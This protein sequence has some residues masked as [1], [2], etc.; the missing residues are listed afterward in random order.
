MFTRIL[1]GCLPPLGR[2]SLSSGAELVTVTGGSGYLGLELVA[3]LLDRNYRVTATVRSVADESK[4]QPLQSLDSAAERLTILEADLLHPGSFDPCVVGAR[5]LFHTASPFRLSGVE[6]P[7]T[8]LIQPAVQGTENVM[9]AA[10]AAGVTRVVLTSS[11]AAIM[12]RPTDKDGP[13]DENDWNYSSTLGGDGLDWYRLSKKLA[14]ERAWEIAKDTGLEL[15]VICP[16]VIIGPPRTPRTDSESLQ[17]MDSVISGREP[18]RG[19]TPM[20]DVRDC[21]AAHI[22]AAEVPEANGHRFLTTTERSI[23]PPEMVHAVKRVLPDLPVVDVGQASPVESRRRIFASK[24]IR[25]LGM[26]FRSIEES[27][28]DMALKMMSLRT[29]RARHGAR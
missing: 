18:T 9:L 28:S 12:G 6:D 3:Q 23:E 14:E 20:V 27:L 15:A 29:E 2:R 4:V 5:T 17:L 16:S 13:F 1:R 25:I 10:A 26:E 7:E 22:A 24:T 11:V 19:A 8:E 21:A